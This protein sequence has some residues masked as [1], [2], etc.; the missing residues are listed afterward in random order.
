MFV[1]DSNCVRVTDLAPC[2]IA[3]EFECRDRSAAEEFRSR[4]VKSIEPQQ[5]D[6]LVFS[7]QFLVVTCARRR[8]DLGLFM[9]NCH[10]HILVCA[11]TSELSNTKFEAIYK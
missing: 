5:F 2:E 11:L 4:A 7:E 1:Q 6:S 10:A 8:V 3:C 9:G